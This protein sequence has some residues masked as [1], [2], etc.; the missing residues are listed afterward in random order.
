MND[1]IVVTD[2]ADTWEA[3]VSSVGNPEENMSQ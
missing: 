1:G 3:E 2:T